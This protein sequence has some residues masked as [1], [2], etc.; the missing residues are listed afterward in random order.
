VTSTSSTSDQTDT[1]LDPSNISDQIDHPDKN[2]NEQ[3][4]DF[5]TCESDFE[6]A[7]LDKSKDSGILKMN[8]SL[9]G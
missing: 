2:G 7:P 4:D 1:V 6:A 3:S 8:F 9:G 5:V